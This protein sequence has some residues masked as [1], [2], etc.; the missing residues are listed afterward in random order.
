MSHDGDCKTL[1][2]ED[3]AAALTATTETFLAAVVPEHLLEVE[4]PA[5][6]LEAC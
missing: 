6:T 5:K 3:P 1:A 4:D 2:V